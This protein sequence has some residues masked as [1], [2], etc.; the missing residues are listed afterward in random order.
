M[1]HNSSKIDQHIAKRLKQL[2]SRA[3][4][5]L[6]ELADQSGV[7]RSM[8]SLVERAET[9]PSAAV[10]DRLASCLNTTLS[11]FFA[12]EKRA[13]S[14]PLS[15]RASQA[16]WVDPGTG[17]IRRNISPP[18]FD[19]PIELVEVTIPPGTKVSFDQTT[20]RVLHQQVWLL[21]GAVKVRLG[22]VTHTLA[23]G[24]CLAMRLDQPIVFHNVGKTTSRHLVALTLG[25]A[26]V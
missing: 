11:A 21:K 7:S 15:A 1:D 3:G 8:I 6:Q 20:R 22:D 26:D 10:L 13:G 5:T 25:R 18:A 14:S 9:S 24:D 4:L 23:A 16:T 12:E 2:R 17:Y 19:S